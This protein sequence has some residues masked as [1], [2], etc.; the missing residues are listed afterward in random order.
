MNEMT[1]LLFQNI[2][3]VILAEGV[4]ASSG[5]A[6]T[7]RPVPTNISSECGMCLEV[8]ANEK[9]QWEAILKDNDIHFTQVND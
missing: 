5:I 3:K 2:R 1:L 4:L 9:C 8:N 6:V 7:V